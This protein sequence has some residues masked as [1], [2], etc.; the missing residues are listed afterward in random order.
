MNMT[1]STPNAGALDFDISSQPANEDQLE[2]LSIT[3]SADEPPILLGYIKWCAVSGFYWGWGS[4]RRFWELV[5]MCDQLTDDGLRLLREYA[6]DEAR[7]WEARHRQFAPASAEWAD[8]EVEAIF[9]PHDYA[10]SF[11]IYWIAALSI[12]ILL[13]WF[14]L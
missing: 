10:P 5:A 6:P 8:Y 1:R 9:E 11:P 12:A 13:A 7:A 2:G 14:F 4:H 3:F